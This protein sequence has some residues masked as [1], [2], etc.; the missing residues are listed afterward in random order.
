[1]TERGLIYL[2][3]EEVQHLL[4]PADIV[5]ITETTMQAHA[6]EAVVMAEPRQMSMR[7]TEWTFK[8]K[9]AALP[10]LGTVGARL[11]ALNRVNGKPADAGPTQFVVL[12]DIH[13]GEVLAFVEEEW[14]Y[15]MRT[16]AQVAVA[17][18]YLAQPDG[19]ITLVGAGAM[20]RGTLHTLLAVYQPRAVRVVARSMASASRFAQGLAEETGIA[21]EPMIDIQAA[22]SD[23]SI[24]ACTTTTREPII[25]WQWIAPGAMVYSMGEHQELDT[26][27]YI[28]ADQLIFDDWKQCQIKSDVRRLITEGVLHVE[29]PYANL[30][31]IVAGTRPGRRTPEERILV[32]SQG[33]ATLDTAVARAAYDAALAD[34]VGQR[35]NPRGIHHSK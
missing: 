15:A 34:G 25:S 24:V 28:E 9:A 35:I 7:P 30:Y 21:V 6:R 11:V 1:M 13:T 23:A 22:V 19:V 33:L 27:A 20:A 10:E 29:H 5:K 3:T 32:R 26:Q 14:S 16:G 8:Y 4:S 12:N 31:D 2:T 17:A 18:R